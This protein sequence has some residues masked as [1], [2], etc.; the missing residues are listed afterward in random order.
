L[1]F[2]DGQGELDEQIKLPELVTPARISFYLRELQAMK[3]SK[4]SITLTLSGLSCTMRIL[5]PEQ[6]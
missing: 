5:T 2:L 1:S 3:Y 6:D 4:Q